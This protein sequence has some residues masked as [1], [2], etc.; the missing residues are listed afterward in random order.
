MLNKIKEKEVQILQG[1]ISNS[2]GKKQFFLSKQTNLNT[3]HDFG[4]AKK[5]LTVRK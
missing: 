1:A 3:F 4:S 5:E 2:D